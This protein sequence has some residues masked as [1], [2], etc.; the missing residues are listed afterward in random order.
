MKRAVAH[1]VPWLEA[2]K[3]GTADKGKVLMATVKGDVHDIGKNIVG[4]V[5]Q[6]NGYEVVDLG[7]MVPAE[8]ILD[9]A[10]AEGVH[11]VGLSGLITPSLDQMV[12]VAREM[13][14][15]GFRLPLVIGGA[16]TS[17]AHTAL[18]VEG[19]YS[20]PVVHVAD[21][22]RAV[23]VLGRLLDPEGSDAYVE[24]V[25]A[26]YA[27]V[28]RRRAAG[29]DRTELLSLAEARARAFRWDW[30][31]YTPP[32]PAHPGVRRFEVGIRELRGTLDWTPFFQTWE[33]KGAYPAILEDPRV[34]AQARSLL[35]DAE[36]LLDRMERD[37]ALRPRGV[38]G[39][40]P[41]S[42]TGDDVEI[43]ADPERSRVLTVVHGLRQ[44]FAK[45][46]RE[47]LCL[48]DFIAPKDSGVPDWM[49][50]F[51][52][53]AG[54]VDALVREFQ[55]AHDDYSAIL[56]KAVADRLA[57]SLAEW[58]HRAVRTGWWG[59][60][61]SETLANEELIAEAYRG[62]RPAPGYPACPDHTEKRTLFA[63]LAV[64]EATGMALTESCAM[65]PPS[66][67][68]GWY[69]AHPAAQY[70]GVGRLGRD[71]V[72]DYARRKGMPVTE[73]ERWLAPNLGYDPEAG[74]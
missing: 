17:K 25:R 74:A 2:E 22:S 9:T 72:E 23:G 54:S 73:V 14:R 39:L 58:T 63:L 52:V 13:E 20:G 16:T 55:D 50:A 36:A 1:L 45:E 31:G 59:Y 30:A 19:A 6:C 27:E 60:A 69:L 56:A 68:S 35:A 40:F 33:L 49:G 4:V 34:G 51:A 53:T 57:E 32:V 5:L 15:Q 44:Q 29:R 3:A 65:D 12:H 70:F 67:V 10:R 11:V 66:S 61:A 47:N 48:S 41:A 18:K 26:E 8:R 28:R 46:G 38:V 42:S 62:I 64:E 21:A 24:E 43:Y 71:Q 7:V 37:G